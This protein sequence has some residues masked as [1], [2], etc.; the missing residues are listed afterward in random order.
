MDLFTPWFDKILPLDKLKEQCPFVDEFKVEYV[1]CFHNVYKVPEFDWKR[2]LN[3]HPD[4]KKKGAKDELTTYHMWIQRGR[5]NALVI[6]ADKVYK[7]FPWND[8]LKRNPDLGKHNIRSEMEAYQ[9]WIN[10]GRKEKRV[11]KYEMGLISEQVRDAFINKLMHACVTETV[12]VK[13]FDWKKYLDKYP[14]LVKA[15]YRDEKRAYEHWVLWGHNEGRTAY[16]VGNDNYYHGFP[17]VD[18]LIKYPDLSKITTELQ[19]YNHWINFGRKE[20]RNPWKIEYNIVPG[21]KIFKQDQLNTGLLQKEKMYIRYNLFGN[22]SP[23]IMDEELSKITK[24]NGNNIFMYKNKAIMMV[25][26]TRLENT[27]GDTM[28]CASWMNALMK[29]DNHITLFS[30]YPI[31]K[32]FIRN[33]IYDNYTC[34]EFGSTALL[35]S[36]MDKAMMNMDIAFIRNVDLLQSLKQKVYLHKIILYG[37][38]RHLH[39][40]SEMNNKFHFVITQSEQLKSK[41]VEKGVLADKIEVIEPFHDKYDFNLP[42]R[43]DNEIRLIYCGTLRDEEN[44]LEI[45]NEFQKIHKERPEV[46]LKIVYGKINGN[47]EFT[48]KIN[49]YIKNG[50]DGITFKH[51]LSHRD[52]CYE[53]ATSDIGICW[54]KNGWGGN[55]EVSTKMKEYKLYGLECL[56]HTLNYTCLTLLKSRN[57]TFLSFYRDISRIFSNKIKTYIPY[58][59]HNG[60]PYDNGGYAVRSH[61]IMNSFNSMYS[62]KMYIGMHKFG[63]PYTIHKMKKVSTY[64]NKI[65]NVYY[66]TLPIMFNIN[67]WLSYLTNI[68]DFKTFHVASAHSNATPILDF[69]KKNNL[70]SIYEVRGMWNVTRLSRE[71]YYHKQTSRINSN[72]NKDI[73]LSYNRNLECE[74]STINRC[75]VPLFITDQL[76]TYCNTFHKLTS[77]C[78]KNTQNLLDYNKPNILPKYPIFYNCA[79]AMNE[80]IDGSNTKPKYDGSLPFII[81]YTGSIVYYE[82]IYEAIIAIEKIISETSLQI[83]F[84]IMG[85]LTPIL[86]EQVKYNVANMKSVLNKPFVKF[87]SK[88]PH[89]QV[90][91]YIRSFD[92]YIIPR[93]GLP[94]TNIVSPL[95]PF[96]PMSL[97]IPLLM[98]DCDCLNVISCNGNNCMVFKQDNERDF[99]E[100]VIHIIKYGYPEELL[101]NGYNYVKQ[102]RNWTN[103]IE[104]VGLYDMLE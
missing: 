56:T 67:L 44:I 6:G 13:E 65:D 83:E 73:I 18:Y 50:I 96:E 71:M 62:D 87:I 53:V 24:Y 34:T 51:N 26:E 94:V 27:A 28:M 91:D 32:T 64:V 10:H 88:V 90:N 20:K 11:I 14:D 82:G 78:D 17:W 47:T 72:Y 59:L 9:H 75:T 37:L 97:K 77:S 57:Q 84:H 61:S 43:S 4:V 54:R 42:K 66:I 99:M 40:I 98:S 16:V 1:K 101:E 49:E 89:N 85:N 76:Y 39:G 7:G 45:I 68:F 8:Y 12:H 41:Y 30:I 63:Y 95:K 29:E 69:C 23:S 36:E 38:E 33:L 70:K 92:L 31:S 25:M 3:D 52:A 103:M 48:K 5:K 46:V 15:G 100:K 79:A 19:C 21:C 104:L 93:V 58:V 74:L 60:M 102:E 80:I 86:T 22:N 2:Y 35:L 81:G 55:G